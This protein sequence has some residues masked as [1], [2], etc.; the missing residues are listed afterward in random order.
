ME[1]LRKFSARGAVVGLLSVPSPLALLTMIP[2][3]KARF[4]LGSLSVRCAV[5]P[6][7]CYLTRCHGCCLDIERN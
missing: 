5:G 3:D 1:S 2:Y 4:P 7:I 6:S